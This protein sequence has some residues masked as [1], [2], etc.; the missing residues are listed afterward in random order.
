MGGFLKKILLVDLFRGLWVTFQNQ[1]PKYIYIEQYPTERPRIAE[2]YR[3][4]PRLNVN[5]DTNE[6]LCI[7]CNLCA[8]ACPE[9][10]IVVTS[11]RNEQTRRK[12]L[13]TFTYD[14]SRCMFLWAVRGRLSTAE[15]PPQA[16]ADPRFRLPVYSLPARNPASILGRPPDTVRVR[17]RE[18]NA[19]LRKGAF[20]QWHS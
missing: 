17:V 14:L 3:G 10:L 18:F 1:S 16:F 13:T 7:S 2:R 6:T 4:A 9:N 5:P 12:D 8:L 19:V 15:V 20:T 11:V